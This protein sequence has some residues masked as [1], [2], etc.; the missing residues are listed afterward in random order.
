M[1][2]VPNEPNS[3]GVPECAEH[4]GNRV[5]RNGLYG[6]A[7][8]CRQRWRCLPENGVPHNFSGTNRSRFVLD[9][10][11]LCVSCESVRHRHEG[12]FAARKY[13]YPLADVA[14][15]LVR[16]GEGA[17]Y[18][19]VARRISGQDEYEYRRNSQLVRHWVDVFT[20]VVAAPFV[21]KRWPSV[22]AIDST[23][24]YPARKQRVGFSVLA[25]VGYEGRRHR[26]RVVA[27]KAVEGRPNAADW[28]QFLGSLEGSPE[29]LIT[30]RDKGQLKSLLGAF[31][32]PPVIRTCRYHEL[33]YPREQLTYSGT[34]RHHAKEVWE[35]IRRAPYRPFYWD[36]LL[37]DLEP[38]LADWNQAQ[39]A[40]LERW[41][42]DCYQRIADDLDAAAKLGI[43]WGWSVGKVEWV[44]QEV[45]AAIEERAFGLRNAYRTGWLLE[46]IRVRL[47]RKDTFEAYLASITK[48]LSNA[49]TRLDHQG[50][51]NDKGGIPSLH[52]W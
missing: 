19:E 29:V 33:T 39:R 44:L 8:R 4:P 13:H 45:R 11:T 49:Q 26:G 24:F 50:R 30:D 28:K 46:L 47:N 42:K 1:L 51:H 34:F 17:S 12:P 10:P 48:S 41:Y 9:H 21:E 31:P 5:V 22:V 20:P 18:T 32:N 27:L 36:Y 7:G 23:S 16:V 52:G 43:Y 37:A 6:S 25:A 3:N 38:F 15:A 35:V 40:G 2:S 14:R